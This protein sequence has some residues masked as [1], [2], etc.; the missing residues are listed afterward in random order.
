MNIYFRWPN[1]HSLAQ[2][3]VISIL[4][5]NVLAIVLIWQQGSAYYL[6]NPSN[7]NIWFAFGRLTG[8]LAQYA[9]LLQLLLIGRA[10]FIERPFGFD[11]LNVVHRWIGY[12]IGSLLIAHPL[13]LTYGAARGN[14]MSLL[15]Q[16][17]DYLTNR[18]H[19]FNAY[20]GSVLLVIVII[21]SIAIVRKKVRYESWYL[22]HLATYV[23]VTLIFLHQIRIGDLRS[24]GAWAYWVALNCIAGGSLIAYRWLR[25]MWLLLFHQFR[26]DHTRLESPG[27]WSVYITGRHMPRFG[28]HP[29]QYAN[30]RFLDAQRWWQSHPFSFSAGPDGRGIR[31]SVRASGDF[32]KTFELLRPGTPVIVDGPLGQFVLARAERKKVLMIAGGIGI[33]PLRALLDDARIVGRDTILLYAN[34][35]PQDIALRAE[36]DS[37]AQHGLVR[38]IYFVN[39]PQPGFES[40]YIDR[41]KIVRLVPDFYDREVFLCGP[42]PMM[43]AVVGQL[44]GLGY[45]DHA[46]HYERFS[47]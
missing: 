8:L 43:K 11:K 14:G 47:F 6:Q 18:Q 26:V 33:T 35:T 40:G 12:T 16:F 37:Y 2:Y 32:T 34:R 24:S 19:V 28:F 13:L 21:S 29:G 7:G 23:A 27:V 17:A 22:V 1:R 39:Q 15:G 31:F 9:L 10:P 42:P 3:A 20:L 38:T 45:P 44:R 4:S 25:P 30:L 41:E 5:A 46:I 36:L